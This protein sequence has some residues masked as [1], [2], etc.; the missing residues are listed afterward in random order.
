[1]ND[2]NAR[3]F[4][5]AAMNSVGGWGVAYT[6]TTGDDGRID[7]R[8]V[9]NPDYHKNVYILEAKKS[10]FTSALVRVNAITPSATND[11]IEILSN[12]RAYRLPDINLTPLGS[13][14]VRITNEVGDPVAGSAYYT[15]LSTGQN[16][17]IINSQWYPESN[18]E[19]SQ[20][21][22]NIRVPTGPIH[23]V[24]RPTNTDL[25]MADTVAVN[26]PEGTQHLVDVSLR[27]K[28][29][30]IHFRITNVN[31]QPVPNAKV[32]LM[33]TSADIYANLVSPF[34]S[35]GGQSLLDK[36][37]NVNIV[38]S[39]NRSADGNQ[40]INESPFQ[41]YGQFNSPPIKKALGLDAV[42]QNDPYLRTA[43][44]NG[45]VDYAF[46]SSE[47]NFDFRIYGLDGSQYVTKKQQVSSTPSKNWK[48]VHVV[49][50]EGRIVQGK[51]TIDEAPVDGAR[52]RYSYQGLVDETF[53]DAQGNYML[54]RVPADT[55]LQFTASKPGFLGM[56]YQ[57]GVSNNLL[58]VGYTQLM[59]S[60]AGFSQITQSNSYGQAIARYLTQSNENRT[61][62]NFRLS[63][64]GELDFSNLM[65][66][67]LEVTDFED[68]ATGNQQQLLLK[69]PKNQSRQASAMA[70]ISG[71]VDVNDGNNTMFKITD[72][73]MNDQIIRTVDFHDVQVGRGST[74]NDVDIAYPQPSALP[75]HFSKN[76]VN[77]GIYP[78]QGGAFVYNG[79]I[80]NPL[81]VTLKRMDPSGDEGAIGGRLAIHAGSFNDNNFGFLEGQEMFGIIE[82]PGPGSTTDVNAFRATGPSPVDPNTGLYAVNQKNEGLSYLLHGFTAQSVIANSRIRRETL[83]LDTRLSTNLLY[84]ENP[85]LNLNIGILAIDMSSRLISP[86]DTPTNFQIP[87]GGGFRVNGNVLRINSSGIQFDGSVDVKSLSMEFAGAHFRRYPHGD[88]FE[89]PD[90]S[91]QVD[92]LSLLGVKPVQVNRPASFGYDAVGWQAWALVIAGQGSYQ[93][94][95]ASISTNGLDGFEP[96]RTIPLSVVRFYST[97]LEEVQIYHEGNYGYRVYDIAD[98]TVQNVFMYDDSFKFS[99]ALNLGIPNFPV[100][101]TAFGYNVAGN[102]LSNASLEGFYMSPIE[103][104]GIVL[105][106]NPDRSTNNQQGTSVN[107]MALSQGRIEIRGAL[108]DEDPNVFRDILF[109]L[110]K[111]NQSTRLDI[112]RNPIQS[113]PLGG[114][115]TGS[116]MILGNIEGNMI[117]QSGQWNHLFIAGDMPEEMGF[118]PDGK[119]MRFDVMGYLSASNQEIKL[120]DIETP[121]GD[122]QLHYD[123]TNHRLSGQLN[124]SG[125]V[126][127]GPSYDGSAQMVID[128]HGFYFMTGLSVSLPSPKIEGMAFML[129]GDYSQRTIEMDALMVQY[130]MYIRKKL[131]IQVDPMVASGIYNQLNSNPLAGLNQMAAQLGGDFLPN[132]YVN[133]FGGQR[134]NGFYF[135]AG[136]SI[137]LPIIPNFE[138]D[139]SPVANFAMGLNG[140]IDVRVGANFGSNS[141]YTAG[142]DVFLD[143][144]FGGGA[145]AGVLCVYGRIGLMISVGMDGT[146][147]SSG[148]YEIEGSANLLLSGLVR[149]GG[150]GCSISDQCANLTCLHCEIDATLE[151]GL[152]GNFTQNSSNFRIVSNV[153]EQPAKNVYEPPP[154]NE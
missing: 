87:L 80:R 82:L 86:V 90:G 12:G 3:A 100:Y 102:S 84:V 65:G 106:F 138:L 81:G 127:N 117:V 110:V 123:L 47:T 98:F 25:Y 29:H 32:R 16:G 118:R 40:S 76:Q 112:D 91:L 8:N 10:G 97:G 139:M 43:N 67:P 24:V 56:T 58:P 55:L 95:V 144:F 72:R 126:A 107:S 79:S 75:M 136:A 27:Y 153:G 4:A 17:I 63:V 150:G 149:A 113:M 20:V 120:S 19:Y 54:N 26:V 135:G 114:S 109:T 125:G 14:F 31:N 124:V 13:M 22:A 37:R 46:K 11:D 96:N 33:D 115:N 101:S 71:L 7:I 15:D 42:V 133:L 148:N 140:G 151:F 2:P 119:R 34:I 41:M 51:V 129:I 132:S 62:I 21:V 61:E 147:Y 93:N 105:R 74:V 1:M 154:S 137:P 28:V 9:Y 6:G 69:L 68:M 83:T 36:Y 64:Y 38:K 85:N 50:D 131:E 70:L 111:T 39:L 52:V 5:I 103:M 145:S 30:R 18:G 152:V 99:G 92:D 78:S 146:F 122:I 59:S 142:F 130:S 60:G 45:R 77:L 94:P 141:V 48:I 53:T 73:G 49:L 88:M 66:F 104:N 108:S 44:Q 23:L 35:L 134:F 116:R 89:I 128:R 143:A 57:E 121:F